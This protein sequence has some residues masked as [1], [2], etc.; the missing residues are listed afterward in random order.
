MSLDLAQLRTMPGG[1]VVT[2]A[3][4]LLREEARRMDRVFQ[5]GEG[6][7]LGIAPERRE[8]RAAIT[9]AAAFLELILAE[10]KTA[11]FDKTSKHVEPLGFYARIA[12]AIR[13]ALISELM[14]KEA[15]R[16]VASES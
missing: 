15:P 3:V 9:A 14:P 16:A 8:T 6:V 13:S 4:T 7:G 2:S 12:A 1:E 11:A 10:G 5:A